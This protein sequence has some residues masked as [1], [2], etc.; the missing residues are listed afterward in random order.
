MNA[1]KVT[2]NGRQYTTPQLAKALNV[3]PRTLYRRIADFG[4]DRAIEICQMS[5]AEYKQHRKDINHRNYKGQR[6]E[7][8]GY[9]YKGQRYSRAD[10]A[11]LLGVN[12]STFQTWSAKYGRAKAIEIAEMHESERKAE[13]ERLCNRKE[14]MKRSD[15]DEDRPSKVDGFE[16]PEFDPDYELKNRI[17]FWIRRYGMEGAIAKASLRI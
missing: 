14:R 3:R 8:W 2:W 11:K 16:A 17:K 9:E 13:I 1:K 7:L 6:P 12:N 4:L 10:L 5:E 15:N